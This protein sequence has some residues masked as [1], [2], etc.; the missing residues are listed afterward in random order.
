MKRFLLDNLE[1]DIYDSAIDDHPSNQTICD[2]LNEQDEYIKK[3]KQENQKLKQEVNDWKQRFNAS[4]KRYETLQQN[5]LKVNNLKN[6][7][8]NKLKQYVDDYREYARY[9]IYIGNM[10]K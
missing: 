9:W 4:E 10:L 7:K 1:D 3:L 5:H 8:I 2:A 6:E